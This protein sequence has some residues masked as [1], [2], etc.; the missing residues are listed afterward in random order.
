MFFVKMTQLGGQTFIRQDDG[1]ITDVCLE[2][3]V[4]PLYQGTISP[5]LADGALNGA[6]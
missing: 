3:V 4:R 2:A 1:A 5:E 6:S